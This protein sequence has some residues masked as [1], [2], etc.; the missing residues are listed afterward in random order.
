MSENLMSEEAKDQT[1]LSTFAFMQH[2]DGVRK[3][4]AISQRAAEPLASTMRSLAHQHIT[5]DIPTCIICLP[6][7]FDF[8]ALQYSQMGMKRHYVDRPTTNNATC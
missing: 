2:L 8:G 7:R 6:G 5:H 3:Q 1:R 4:V